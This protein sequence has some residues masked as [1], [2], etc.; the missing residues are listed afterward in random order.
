MLEPN[1]SHFPFKSSSSCKQVT[2]SRTSWF[3]HL[4]RSECLEVTAGH[5][6]TERQREA[7]RRFGRQGDTSKRILLISMILALHFYQ[8]HEVYI[9]GTL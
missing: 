2:V 3:K 7:V 1:L 9:L 4:G 5:M 8:L 6:N